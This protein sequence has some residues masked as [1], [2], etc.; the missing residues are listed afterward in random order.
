MFEKRRKLNFHNIN[1]KPN[2]R[3]KHKGFIFVCID[4]Y[5]PNTEIQNIVNK[6]LTL[7]FYLT[8]CAHNEFINWKSFSS[9]IFYNRK[10]QYWKLRTED[11]ELSTKWFSK[12]QIYFVL[13]RLAFKIILN[14]AEAKRAKV[15][16]HFS[17]HKR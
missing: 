14:L 6:A 12:T 15:Q 17:L 2:T 8:N 11:A 4:L 1:A 5:K 7:K 10:Q 9:P 13:I 16:N 3:I